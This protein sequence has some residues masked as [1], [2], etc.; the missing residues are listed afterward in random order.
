MVRRFYAIIPCLPIGIILKIPISLL[1]S[2][3]LVL[4]AEETAPSMAPTTEPIPIAK[5][6]ITE[7][8]ID[9]TARALT[10]RAGLGVDSDLYQKLRLTLQRSLTDKSG[11]YDF[12]L[13]AEGSLNRTDTRITNGNKLKTDR[14]FGID[15]GVTAGIDYNITNAHAI[16]ASLFLGKGSRISVKDYDPYRLGVRDVSITYSSIK[17]GFDIDYKFRISSD[18][19]LSAGLGFR[20]TNYTANATSIDKT[21]AGFIRLY[22]DHEGDP[23]PLPTHFTSE[24]F[25]EADRQLQEA[26]PALWNNGLRTKKAAAGM[27]AAVAESI[28]NIAGNRNIDHAPRKDMLP[29]PRQSQQGWR[30]GESWDSVQNL[31][32][33]SVCKTINYRPIDRSIQRCEIY[34][35]PVTQE[36]SAYPTTVRPRITYN[37]IHN[38][39]QCDYAHL[40]LYDPICA[41]N[42]TAEEIQNSVAVIRYAGELTLQ[43]L[44]SAGVNLDT[45][46]NTVIKYWGVDGHNPP[47][48]NVSLK[49]IIDEGSYKFQHY[50]TIRGALANFGA[51]LDTSRLGDPGRHILQVK[52]NGSVTGISAQGHLEHHV[53]GTD[54]KSIAFHLITRARQIRKKTTPTYTPKSNLRLRHNP[55]PTNIAK[56]PVR[57][58]AKRSSSVQNLL[59]PQLGLSLRLTD[60]S[61]LYAKYKLPTIN[62]D[63]ALAHYASSPQYLT[64]GYK[65]HF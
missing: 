21:P 33:S 20:R 37:D 60:S 19:Q 18:L 16:E 4:H 61:E 44:E 56:N 42:P 54:N 25:L 7:T 26:L 41:P 17:T 35:E 53:T 59:Q 5:T 52:E 2:A 49:W 48:E 22:N 30:L 57:A 28:T 1:L 3:L 47:K 14:S 45:H 8:Q 23:N 32:E 6:P 34:A 9:D 10:A 36:T 55:A 43:L 31:A 58:F 50:A 13:G 12:T 51:T 62:T 63:S 15:Y 27:L 39:V 38:T 65:Y 40:T 11:T 64:F 29:I 46:A 24:D